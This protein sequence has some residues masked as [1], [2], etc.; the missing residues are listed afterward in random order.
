MSARPSLSVGL[1]ERRRLGARLDD[2]G[3]HLGLGSASHLA[4]PIGT[5]RR[6]TSSSSSRSVAR[7]RLPELV[8]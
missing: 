7:S 3:D 8:S 1:A 6:S 5:A 2:G 4:S